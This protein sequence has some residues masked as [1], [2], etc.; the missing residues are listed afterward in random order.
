[1]GGMEEERKRE[2]RRRGEHKEEWKRKEESGREGENVH[3]KC[4]ALQC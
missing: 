3:S 1:M 4:W 2:V